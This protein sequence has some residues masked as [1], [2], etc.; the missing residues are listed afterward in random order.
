MAN[1]FQCFRAGEP[2]LFRRFVAERCERREDGRRAALS[3]TYQLSGAFFA[4]LMNPV[5]GAQIAPATVGRDLLVKAEIQKGLSTNYASSW[6]MVRGQNLYSGSSASG[7]PQIMNGAKCKSLWTGTTTSPATGTKTCTGPLTQNM[8]SR[9]D[10]PGSSIPLLGDAA[11][12]D[13]K[14]AILALDGTINSLDENG[15]LTAGARLCESFNDASSY[16]AGGK[17]VSLDKGVAT[18]D[19]LDVELYNPV[20]YPQIGE[21]NISD[22]T[23]A[24]ATAPAL[25][26][27]DTRDWFA[28]HR[29]SC[30]L[31]MADG[32]VRSISD[33]NGDGYFNPGFNATGFTAAD[34]GYTEGPCEI[35]SFEVF[36]GTWLSVPGGGK[37][38]F[39]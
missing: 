12:G 32:S 2:D 1:R 36:C 16:V 34:D 3:K 15:E 6:F 30:N 29:T 24:A 25:F 39:E 9:S 8:I 20:R 35:S 13:A 37:G 21:T 10:I 18:F 4:S 5:S 27:Q 23:Y 22:A 14:E 31:L 26:L 19:G 33:L 17:I 38:N 7:G 28:V 11:Y